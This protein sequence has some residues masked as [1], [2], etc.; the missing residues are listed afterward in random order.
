[1]RFFSEAFF[2]SHA[3]GCVVSI[4]QAQGYLS[5]LEQDAEREREKAKE[6]AKKNQAPVWRC[7][8]CGRYGC[9]VAPYVESYQ[10]V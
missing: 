5:A 1:M 8:A 6:L 10:D 7:A 2:F 4:K 9:G 3:T